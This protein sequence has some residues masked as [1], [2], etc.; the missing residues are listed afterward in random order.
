MHVTEVIPCGG[1]GGDAMEAVV[2]GGE[3]GGG[4]R[5]AQTAREG[6]KER[7]KERGKVPGACLLRVIGC[8]SF[9]FWIC[10]KREKKKGREKVARSDAPASFV[11]AGAGE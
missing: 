2:G 9:V 4:G 11:C 10:Q 6:E 5:G 3:W 1:A 8:L 7:R